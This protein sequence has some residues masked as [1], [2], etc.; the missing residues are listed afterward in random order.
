[1]GTSKYQD[2]EDKLLITGYTQPAGYHQQA[3]YCHQEIYRK[4]EKY[5]NVKER[6]LDVG[7]AE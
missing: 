3:K 6:T 2:I 1:M 4:K 7:R 5:K